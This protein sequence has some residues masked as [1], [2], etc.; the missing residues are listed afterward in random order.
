MRWKS[1]YDIYKR[2]KD[3]YGYYYYE[4]DILRIT[5]GF[6]DVNFRLIVKPGKELTSKGL[7]PIYATAEDIL[8]EIKQ[9]YKDGLKAI[10]EFKAKEEQ[11]IKLLG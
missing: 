9:G 2:R 1:A 7:V 3:I 5:R 11:S 10:E 6:H 4:E 8:N